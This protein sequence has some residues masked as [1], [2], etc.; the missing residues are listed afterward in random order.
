MRFHRSYVPLYSNFLKLDILV[1]AL[2][3]ILFIVYPDITNHIYLYHI[4]DLVD[5]VQYKALF[6]LLYWV[7]CHN[8]FRLFKNWTLNIL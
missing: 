4:F 8:Q 3:S 5:L 7:R 2:S 1:V 6:D